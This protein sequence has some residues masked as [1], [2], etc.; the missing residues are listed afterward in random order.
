[1]TSGVEVWFTLVLAGFFLPFIKPKSAWFKKKRQTGQD[2]WKKGVNTKHKK[3]ECKDKFLLCPV[4][5]T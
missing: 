3:D 1:M 5:M 2:P 4:A